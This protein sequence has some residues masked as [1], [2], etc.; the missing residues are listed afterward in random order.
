MCMGVLKKEG[1][2]MRISAIRN[3]ESAYAVSKMNKNQNAKSVMR[4][5]DTTTKPDTVAFKAHETAKGVG[6]GALIGVAGLTLLT[7]GA[8]APVAYGVYA[9]VMGTAGG[10][11]GTAIEDVNRENEENKNS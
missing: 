10:L 2:I 6:I 1:K 5:H 9:A 7:G 8:A 11:L 3:Y 4:T